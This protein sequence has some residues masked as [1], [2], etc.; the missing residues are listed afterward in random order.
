M[1]ARSV[2]SCSPASPWKL[3]R[4]EDARY[5]SMTSRLLSNI[6]LDCLSRDDAS[7]A[8]AAVLRV[9][10]SFVVHGAGP[11]R[12]PGSVRPLLL[13]RD[14]TPPVVVSSLARY[15]GKTIVVFWRRLRLES[16]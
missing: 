14:A 15:G 2:A 8:S 12:A 13:P 10:L 7:D 16:K 6:E 1:V 3:R 11:C 4:R 5:V 9:L